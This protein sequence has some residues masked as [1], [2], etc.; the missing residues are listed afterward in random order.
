MAER[1]PIVIVDG[2]PAR[3]PAGDTLP[4]SAVP[5]GGGVVAPVTSRIRRAV[6][7]SVPAGGGWTDLAW[8]TSGYQANGAFWS[9]GATVTIPEAGY[10]QIAAEATFDGAGLLG[11]VQA[12]MQVIV[13][14]S[15][16]IGD[17]SKDVLPG[18]TAALFNFSQRNY[19]AGDT[20]KVQ[21]RHTNATAVNVLAQGDHSPDIILTK[22]TGAKGDAGAGTQQTY[23][24][25]ARPVEPGP[26][27]WWRK[28]AD[29]MRIDT[30]I[31]NDGA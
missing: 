17:D 12:N 23:V 5:G 4:A 11:T 10:Y 2:L 9:T 16:V 7:Q 28:S 30:L 24:Q 14:G 19:G 27:A 22:L 29:G 20:I 6:N 26:W 3:L 8:D 31:L 21:V 25:T 18:N 13:N 1:A 15:T